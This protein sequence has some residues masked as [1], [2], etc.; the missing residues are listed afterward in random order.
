MKELKK[1][2]ECLNDEEFGRLVKTYF[3]YMTHQDIPPNIDS[4][5]EQIFRT[6]IKAKCDVQLKDRIRK[7]KGKTNA[8]G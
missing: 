4:R 1:Y 7:R 3:Y 2:M 6:T 5:A 8:R